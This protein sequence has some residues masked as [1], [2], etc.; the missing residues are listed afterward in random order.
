[1]C[2]ALLRIFCGSVSTFASIVFE[3]I[4]SIILNYFSNGY[5]KSQ[6]C[7]AIIRTAGQSQFRITFAADVLPV[8]SFPSFHFSLYE[9]L[10]SHDASCLR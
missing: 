7:L 10:N 3:P 2:C 4:I 1:M 5:C 6:F 8:H 9:A